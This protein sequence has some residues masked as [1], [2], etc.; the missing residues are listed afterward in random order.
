MKLGEACVCLYASLLVCARL[1]G[2][3]GFASVCIWIPDFIN[4]QEL[5]ASQAATF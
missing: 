3:R 1:S 5:I 2:R 4:V